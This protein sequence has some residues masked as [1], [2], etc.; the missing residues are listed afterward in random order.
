MRLE[1]KEKVLYFDKGITRRKQIASWLIE[2]IVM[3]GL[4]F[5]LKQIQILLGSS[6][7][8]D[9]NK[10]IQFFRK[11]IFLIEDETLKYII[12]ENIR[13]FGDST[14][15]ADLIKN[16]FKDA[17]F[18]RKTVELSS[19]R[20]GKKDREFIRSQL[21]KTKPRKFIFGINKKGDRVKANVQVI[22]RY[23]KSV[24]VLRG[25]DGRFI[26]RIED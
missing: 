3:S 6:D 4:E 16:I 7:P 5:N 1:N 13:H 11:T 17:R 15:I 22:Q 24:P 12:L 19:R 25:K 26:K 21:G 9:R 8:N 23:N 14:I 20:L 10:G 2:E 18:R